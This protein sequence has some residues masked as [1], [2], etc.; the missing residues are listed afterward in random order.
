MVAL[1]AQV[2]KPAYGRLIEKPAQV[3]RCVVRAL[4]SDNLGTRRIVACQSPELVPTVPPPTGVPLPLMA[5]VTATSQPPT[6]PAPAPAATSKSP[7][8][9][10]PTPSLPTRTSVPETFPDQPALLL[11][12]LPRDRSGVPFLEFG[13]VSQRPSLRHG[14]TGVQLISLARATNEILDEQLLESATITGA[15]FSIN[16]LSSGAAILVGDFHS[17]PEVLRAAA[18]TGAANL[19]TY[20]GL[21]LFAV[22]RY[23]DL[24][25]AV[26]DSGTLLL[27]QGDEARALIEETID[28]RLDG[29]ELD[30]SL[31]AFLVR[32]GPVDF[33]HARYP[34]T[35]G[36]SQGSAAFPQP[37]FSV[38]EGTMNEATPR[39]CTCIWIS[40]RRVRQSGWSLG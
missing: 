1:I 2:V 24:Y 27:A 14:G 21:E 34:D 38:G 5:P 8:T 22:S 31:A 30:Q 29:A 36:L 32:T 39:A 28:R 9:A 10:R 37:V 19:Y 18:V 16:G 26:P 25:L 17:F 12:G 3:N 20:R 15:A 6:T 13:E 4:G 11:S 33:L 23:Y 7:P 35:E 40:P